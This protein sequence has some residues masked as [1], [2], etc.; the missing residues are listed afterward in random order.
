[1]RSQ[2]VRGWEGIAEQLFGEIGNGNVLLSW[3][4]TKPD[5][6]CVALN[7]G[8]RDTLKFTSQ[9]HENNYFRTIVT[10]FDS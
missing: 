9:W 5:A 8:C 10:A 6:T 3:L 7:S 2:A 4:L 1:M